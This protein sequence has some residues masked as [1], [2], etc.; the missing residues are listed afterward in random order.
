MQTQDTCIAG[1]KEHGQRLD[2]VV[3]EHLGVSRSQV[4][5]VLREERILHNGE[6]PKKAGSSVKEG[7]T[8]QILAAPPPP[9][10]IFPDIS[11][12][13]EHPDY[14]VVEKPAGL[15]VHATDAH[16]PVTLAAWLEKQYPELTGVG[17]HP[18]RPGIVHRLDKDASG[19]LVVARNQEMFDHLKRQFKERTVGKYYDVL[20]HGIIDRADDVI[21]FDID[22]GKDGRMVSRPKT[23]KISLRTVHD[24]QDGKY[25]KTSF[26]VVHRYQRHTRLKVRI[27]TGRM[28]Q[29]RVHLFA[30]GH[31]V[32]GDT[33]YKND[34]LAKKSDV[35][36]D[37]LFL[38]A[39]RLSFVDLTR[40]EKEFQIELPP[41]LQTYLEQIPA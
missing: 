11:V 6:K 41:E 36:I 16:E 37:R 22:R 28:H 13:S 24:I 21:D 40:E 30:Y 27:H 32:V 5:K 33:L 15:L 25:A 9:P 3:A 12:I 29:I 8:I 4:L 19:L 2:Q 7:D 18:V 1:S 20:V 17:E 38:H 14:L 31:P 23:E 10:A 26:D 35:P 34:A 39:A